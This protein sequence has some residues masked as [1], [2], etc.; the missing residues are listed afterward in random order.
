MDTA[1]EITILLIFC[2]LFTVFYIQQTFAAEKIFSLIFTIYRNDTV[3]LENL[4]IETGETS[5]FPTRDTG[6]YIE[7]LTPENISLFK[8]NLGISFVI[9]IFTQ[10]KVLNT[11]VTLDENLI[12]VRLPYFNEARWIR[13]YHEDKK[14]FEI[15]LEKYFCN[16][17][18]ICEENK[19]ENYFRCEVDCHCGN[20]ICE[21]F[22]EENYE[23]CP[24]DCVGR[25]FPSDIIVYILIFVVFLIFILFFIK[26]LKMVREE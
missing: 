17:N 20:G 23:N 16:N 13:I 7:I 5:H 1:R 26:K 18:G 6:Y 22:Y 21:S 9:N 12:Q 4:I 10:E 2:L 14:I 19:G 15:D 25:G 24:K 8:S 11:T 3:V